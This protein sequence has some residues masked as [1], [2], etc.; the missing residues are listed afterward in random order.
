MNTRVET[1]A[2]SDLYLFWLALDGV[3]DSH[4]L[5]LSWISD[6]GSELRNVS[7]M[8][9]L[10]GEPKHRNADVR[11]I[12]GGAPIELLGPN[13]FGNRD[14]T[15]PD[16]A[17]NSAT[18]QAKS[19]SIELI[20]RRAAASALACP[21]RFAIQ[22]ALGP[23]AAFGSEHNQAML[24]GNVMDSLVRLNRTSSDHAVRVANDLWRHLT[25]GE[26]A[27][28]FS[29]RVVKRT[30]PSAHGNWT[31][32]LEGGAKRNDPV[33][34]AYIATKDQQP[35]AIDEIAPPTTEF[36]PLRPRLIT[37]SA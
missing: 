19:K 20:D 23:S 10:I 34:L 4:R 33:S 26:R 3:G 14:R 18:T 15:R 8:V 25:P 28:S 17:S 5:T 12:A 24:F 9:T 2:L 1:A 16:P 6:M 36:L 7:P 27:S 11:A 30:G 31:L 29:K 21:R 37:T 32:T 22:W 35:V 13:I